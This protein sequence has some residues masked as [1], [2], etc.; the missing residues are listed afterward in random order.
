AAWLIDCHIT[1]AGG[2]RAHVGTA[3]ARPPA[4]AGPAGAMASTDSALPRT[5]TP[6]PPAATEVLSRWI[7]EGARI[8]GASCTL[9]TL[10]LTWRNPSGWSG[11]RCR[12]RRET[13][14]S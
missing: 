12:P 7:E 5:G 10:A 14:V 3:S 9:T 6:S 11:W 8:A 4:T 1:P 13:K 2:T